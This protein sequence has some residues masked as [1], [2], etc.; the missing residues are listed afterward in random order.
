[1][2]MLNICNLYLCMCMK[3]VQYTD[4]HEYEWVNITT[5]SNKSEILLEV[6]TYRVSQKKH[7]FVFDS[8]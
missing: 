8:P 6:F 4:V 2:T 3:P 7:P 1:M 5:K